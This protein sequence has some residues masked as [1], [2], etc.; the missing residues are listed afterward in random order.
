MFRRLDSGAREA[1]FRG[2]HFSKMCFIKATVLTAPTIKAQPNLLLNEEDP[3]KKVL[4]ALSV[5]MMSLV[6]VGCGSSPDGDKQ[7]LSS[8]IASPSL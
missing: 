5:V 7:R 1:C 8:T 6:V 4:C 3:M 2:L